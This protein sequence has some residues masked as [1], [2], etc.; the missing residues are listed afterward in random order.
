MFGVAGLQHVY[1]FVLID[2]LFFECT[3]LPKRIIHDS[4]RTGK[5]DG[6]FGERVC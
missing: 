4:P 5:K 2:H 1:N 6:A 3:V